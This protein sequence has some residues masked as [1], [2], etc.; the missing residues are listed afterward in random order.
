MAFA[1][2]SLKEIFDDSCTN[3]DEQSSDFWI[4]VSALKRFFQEEGT[5]PLNGAL[6]DMTATTE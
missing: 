5:L 6:P 4:A 1:A 3:V 2:A